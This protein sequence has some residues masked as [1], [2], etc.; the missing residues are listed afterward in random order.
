MTVSTFR[1]DAD[2]ETNSVD[3]RI[4][5]VDTAGV[6]WA[7]IRGDP[8]GAPVNADSPSVI[9]HIQIRCDGNTDKWDVFDRNVHLFDTSSLPDGDDIDSATFE[10]VGDAGN[11]KSDSFTSSVALVTTTPASNT[12]IVA[13]DYDQFGTADQA[14]RITIDNI[15]V[16]DSTFNQFTLNSTGR[17]NIAKAGVTKFGIRISD[18]ADDVEPT[19]ASGAKA[20]VTFHSADEAEG[21]D[22]RPKLVVTHSTA[23]TF[24]PKAMVF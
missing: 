8:G 19:W 21:A 11:A 9:A 10:V 16:D 24:I 17:G 1:S 23:T 15:V 6:T 18:D 14:T 22:L 2:P 4:Q 12:D 5:Y 3:S 7:T 20:V 13:D